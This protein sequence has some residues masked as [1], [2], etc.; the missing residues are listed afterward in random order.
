MANFKNRIA[1]LEQLQP[2]NLQHLSKEELYL[3]LEELCNK[4]EIQDWLAK[5]SNNCILESINQLGIFPQHI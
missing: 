2:D 4:P 1:K 3:K 5:E